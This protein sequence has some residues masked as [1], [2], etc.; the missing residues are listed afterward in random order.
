MENSHKEKGY[1]GRIS[2]R[3][4][5]LCM[6]ILSKSLFFAKSLYFKSIFNE[7]RYYSLKWDTR[8]KANLTETLSKSMADSTQLYNL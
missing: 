3:N 4:S 2:T 8:A 1:S 7:N 6:N 5:I